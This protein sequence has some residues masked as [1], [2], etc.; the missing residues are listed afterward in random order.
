MSIDWEEKD[1]LKKLTNDMSENFIEVETQMFNDS[2]N[3]QVHS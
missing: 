2:M 1:N 3:S